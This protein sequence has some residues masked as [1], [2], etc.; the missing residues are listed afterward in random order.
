MPTLHEAHPVIE[1]ISA[2]HRLVLRL[3]EL[4]ERYAE[5]VRVGLRP[6]PAV[7]RRFLR[8]L[9]EFADV[10]HHDKEENILFAWLEEQ[11]LP[12][13]VGPLALLREEHALGRELRL[14]LSL[15]LDAL[16]EDPSDGEVRQRFHG[17]AR[18]FVDLLRAHIEKEEAVLLPLARRVS[19]AVGEA[20][21][22]AEGVRAE[23][24]RWLESIAAQACAWPA[25]SCP[26]RPHGSPYAF[27]RLCEESLV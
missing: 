18:R 3:L 9:R 21:V 7:G 14:A 10:S 24:H 20:P 4:F 27:G 15:A 6:D 8:L 2:E 12:H 25:V 22:V 11:G 17:L 19:R 26:A 5:G 13:E 23:P 1:V 16:H